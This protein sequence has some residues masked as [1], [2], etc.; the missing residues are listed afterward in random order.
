[1]TESKKKIKIDV[2]S[3]ELKT[4]LNLLKE[5]SKTQKEMVK[6]FGD[7]FNREKE[8][9]K[10][11]KE[12]TNELKNQQ[13]I[14]ADLVQKRKE[15]EL[16]IQ[17]REL[18][19]GQPSWID[20]YQRYKGFSGSF[21]RMADVVSEQGQQKI[22]E[23]DKQLLE[24]KE[25]R[26]RIAGNLEQAKLEGQDTTALE[27]QLEAQDKLIESTDL[28]RSAS[29]GETKTQLNNINAMGNAAKKVDKA[30][31][32]MKEKVLD[33]IKKPFKDLYENVT[34]VVTAML[35]LENGIASFNTAT[36]LVT[37]TAA[38]E[39]QMKYGL[40]S[41]QNYAFTRAK[42]LLNIQSDEDLM[43]MNKDQRD[44]FLS[45]MEKYSQWFDKMES[46]GVLEQIQEMQLT[47]REL[48]EELAM[49]FLQWVAANKDA[50]MEAIKGIFEIIKIV[51]KAV[52][53]ILNFIKPIG[54]P[55][56]YSLSNVGTL[57][58]GITNTNT[59][60]TT[61]TIN[62]NTTN[63]AT[64]VLSSQQALDNW[65]KEN[66]SNLAKQIVGVIGG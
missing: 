14:L 65:S 13:K 18:E 49:D 32:K 62:A 42:E 19:K 24:Q 39:Q 48:Y 61:I 64:G 58:D 28:A 8:G 7:L 46:S 33:L 51:G 4:A 50:I 20:Q 31:E 59:K 5:M 36:S 9:V 44:R 6:L 45:Y 21:N 16:T 11:E 43:Y 15:L 17:K 41:A 26:A 38:R 63:N 29:I 34:K 47:F 60:N 10:V 54:S 30:F 53:D 12:R 66:W 35:K 52:I 40:T 1:M 27:S 2:D 55:N 37:N 22:D 56:T 57:S 3:K 25:E 23:F